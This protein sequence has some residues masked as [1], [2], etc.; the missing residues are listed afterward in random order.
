MCGGGGGEGGRPRNVKTFITQQMCEL[1]RG[2]QHNLKALSFKMFSC[3]IPVGVQ[4]HDISMG[5]D[6]Y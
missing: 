5:V 1:S 4:G 6:A 3:Q 2:L